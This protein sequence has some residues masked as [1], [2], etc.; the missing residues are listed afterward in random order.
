MESIIKLLKFCGFWGRPYQKFSLWQPLCHIAVLVV[1][2]LA[3]GVIFIVRNSSNFASAISAAIE[4]MGFINTI[5]LGT[6][7]LYHRSAL[8]NAYGDI[9]IA[10][11]IGKSSS[12]GDVQRNIEFLE[13]STNFLF[14]GYTVFQSVVGTGYALTIPSLT[15]VYYV[16]TGQWPPLHGIF[17][18]E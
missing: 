13:K 5:L 4:S 15:V 17:E 7:M 1:C 2:L 11:R 6:T 14:K 9:R 16:Q 3:P 10:L 8:E 18:A 12:I